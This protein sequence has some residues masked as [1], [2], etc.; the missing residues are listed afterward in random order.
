MSRLVV[1]GTHSGAGKTTVALGL[2]AA[3]A[4]RGLRVQPYKIGPDYIDPIWHTAVAGTPSRNLD[5]WMLSK[6]AIRR[7]ASQAADISIIEGVMGMF[8]GPGSTADMAR[9]LEA[10]VVL[11]VDAQ[12]MAGSVAAIVRGFESLDRRVP[13]AGV[14]LNRV[15]GEGHYRL[16]QEAIDKHC[17]AQTLG[18]LLKDTQLELPERHLGLVPAH[19][20]NRVRD[21]AARL[22]GHLEKTVNLD[23]VLKLSRQSPV[24]GVAR[25]L[26]AKP[27]RVRIAVARDEA[28]CFYYEDNLALLRAEG[29]EIAFFSPLNDAHLPAGTSAVYFGGG[30]PELFEKQLQASLLATE[31]RGLPIY[32]ECGGLM[33]LTMIGLIPGRVTMTE[34]LQNFGYCE[35]TGVGSFLVRPGEIV[36]GHEFHYSTWDAEGLQPA[37][38]VRRRRTNVERVEGYG[39]PTIHASY[40]HVHFLSCPWLARRFVRA[41][42]TFSTVKTAQE[43]QNGLDASLCAGRGGLPDA[44][45]V[46]RGRRRRRLRPVE[47]SR[48]T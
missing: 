48:E 19:E 47:E 7:I 42:V 36:R 44:D 21:L 22:V 26:P 43:N 2:M 24:C 29:A 31:L 13:V 30:F 18:Y 5:L 27:Q 15:S 35:A 32:A 3:L 39:S 14:I 6:S 10:P 25:E 34:R 4:Q 40:V 28:F 37:F 16:L 8:D 41:A 1:A 9:L 11:V 20:Q 17:R 12:G 45:V 33:F 46:P 23:A 38:Q